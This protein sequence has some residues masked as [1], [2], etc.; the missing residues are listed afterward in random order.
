MFFAWDGLD[1]SFY[2]KLKQEAGI[3]PV[4]YAPTK[5]TDPGKNLP[6]GLAAIDHGLLQRADVFVGS[7]CSSFAVEIAAY[8]MALD[9]GRSWSYNAVDERYFCEFPRRRSTLVLALFVRQR[10]C[11]TEERWR[12]GLTSVRLQTHFHRTFATRAY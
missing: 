6:W 11:A 4:L 1:K 10:S 5:G 2:D 3:E 9:I 8:R 7:A 12:W